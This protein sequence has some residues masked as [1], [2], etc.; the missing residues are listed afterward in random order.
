MVMLLTAMVCQYCVHMYVCLN[1][2]IKF[3]F[4]LHIMEIYIM[5]LA[6]SVAM[7]D[8]VFIANLL[9]SLFKTA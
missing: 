1:I 5:R 4:D 6:S 3:L 9:L 7:S 8:S 2:N